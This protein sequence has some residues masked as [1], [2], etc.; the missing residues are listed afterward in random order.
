MAKKDKKQI[1]AII[2]SILTAFILW[3]YATGDKNQEKSK[4]IQN[5]P[6]SIV[7]A[8]AIE[9]ANLALVPNQNFTVNL[10]IKGSTLKILSVT[11]DNFK[12]Q[13]DMSLGY[14]KKG[15]NNIPVEI[16][17][18][19]DG[20]MVI[21]KYAF[22]RVELDTLREK[23]VQVNINVTGMPQKGYGYLQPV[24]KPTAVVISGPERFVNM[25]SEVTGEID[26]NEKSQD[27]NGSIVIKPVDID[28]VTVQNVKIEPKYVDVTVPIKPA[29]EVPII[30]KT[31]GNPP[32]NKVLKDIIPDIKTLTVIG[33]KNF[34][35][36]INQIQTIP[37]N[38]SSLDS[39]SSTELLL[40]VPPGVSIFNDMRSINV[41][42]VLENV[43]GNT[44]NVPIELI[45]ETDGFVYT[46]NHSILTVSFEGAES[47][48]N[49]LNVQSIRAMVDVNG[50]DEGE[51]TV[52]ASINLPEGV[53]V[54]DSSSL[55]VNVNVSKKQQ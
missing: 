12:L 41:T 2:F 13:A 11:P 45:N 8:E 5:I 25:V 43:V 27:V 53:K 52:T 18:I 24:A 40:N 30:I 17:N 35:D 20:V 49:T 22:I 16:T 6:V 50:M 14:L 37:F 54:K 7:N 29:K 28:G 42:F 4:E 31:T 23:N 39:S 55:K 9:E 1:V 46:A 21:D 15:F 51:H 38:I 10:K 19:P 34:I 48:I 32:Q 33:E 26:V 47:V 3:I 44:F 36:R